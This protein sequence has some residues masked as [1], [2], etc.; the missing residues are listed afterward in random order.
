MNLFTHKMHRLGGLLVAALALAAILVPPAIARVDMGMGRVDADASGVSEDAQ[1]TPPVRG[2]NYYAG[3]LDAQVRRWKGFLGTQAALDAEKAAA[4]G[5]IVLHKSGVVVSK[6]RA[7]EPAAAQSSST[8]FQWGD[9]G[10]GAG[11]AFGLT[12]L[13]GGGLLV[14]RRQ[15][16]AVSAS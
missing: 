8:A 4:T 10:I 12:A 9:A 13:A 1:P 11:F 3:G 14:A 7:S 5:W 2:E 15:R 16:G 6:R